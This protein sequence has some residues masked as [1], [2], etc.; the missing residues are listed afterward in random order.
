MIIL[1]SVYNTAHNFTETIKLLNLFGCDCYNEK[2]NNIYINNLDYGESF[3]FVGTV[4][5][6]STPSWTYCEKSSRY[7]NNL[8][9]IRRISFPISYVIMIIKNIYNIKTL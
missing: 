3:I 7:S 4:S 8:H 6:A 2:N 5:N 9:T 1:A